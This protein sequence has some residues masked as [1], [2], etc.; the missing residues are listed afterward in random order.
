VTENKLTPPE[1]TVTSD[2]LPGMDAELEGYAWLP[3]MLAKARAT[4]AGTARGFEFGCP[5][6]HTLMAR[7][8]V[9]PELVSDL[10][11][12][13][14]DDADVLA[15]LRAHGIP[16]ARDAWFDAV[17]VEDELQRHGTYLRVRRRDALPEGPAGRAFMGAEHGA[18]VSLLFID[19]EPGEAEEWHSH[20]SEEVV[21]VHAG[22]ATFF[23]G[24]LQRR[25]L[26]DG[27]VARIPAGV[28][29]R[30]ANTGSGPFRAIAA[31]GSPEI[32]TDLR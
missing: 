26:R 6:D 14:D 30:Y 27:D 25:I 22:Q 4:R 16:S 12:R 29:H 5:V 10:V 1:T 21:A 8:G 32:V 19:A 23:L 2:R 31:H 3:R 20:P 15:Q 28:L 13:Y 18:S 9:S 17:G 24:R 11:R 7:L